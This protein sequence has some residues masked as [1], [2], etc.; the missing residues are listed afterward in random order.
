MPKA[1][2]VIGGGADGEPGAGCGPASE[3]C[4]QAASAGSRPWVVVGGA[5]DL[6][7]L[8]EHGGHALRR[9]RRRGQE[10]QIV[11]L[12]LVRAVGDEAMQVYIKAEVAAEALHDREHARV[13]GCDRR[14]AVLLLHAVP[15]VLHHR[16]RQ[17]PGDGG[18]QRRVVA[19]AHRHRARER[20]LLASSRHA[21]F[22]GPGS[23]RAHL[24][25]LSD[26]GRRRRH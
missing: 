6:V 14:Q 15:H 23:I 12:L 17:P 2:S 7:D 10:A 4:T 3:S 5:N 1:E 18:Q 22:R 21:M 8:R 25:R 24:D 16:P 20:R 19:Q 26:G 9:R 13:Q 11:A